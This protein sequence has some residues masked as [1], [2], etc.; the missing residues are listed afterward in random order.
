M[1]VGCK[2]PHGLT[3]THAGQT[4][5]LNGANVGYDSENP[6]RNGAA[7]DA[8]L[9]ASGVG[10]TILEGEQ[11]AAF[12]EW[13]EISAKGP[14]PVQSGAIFITE[15]KG[16]ATKEAQNLESE[17]TGLDG[18]DPD[19]DLPKGLETDADAATKPTKSKG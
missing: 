3:V 15:A 16:D 10:L 6:W 4:I 17:K 5:V 19:K 1:F 12:K 2:L 13:C 11:A 18:L 9:R 14:G 7:P 8:E